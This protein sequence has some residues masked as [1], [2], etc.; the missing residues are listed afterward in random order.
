ML[1]KQSSCE[2]FSSTNSMDETRSTKSKDSTETDKK[3]LPTF[4]N[5]VVVIRPEVFYENEDCQTDNKFMKS[6][7]LKRQSTNDLAQIEFDKFKETLQSGGIK[8]VEFA[9]KDSRAPDAIFPDWFTT[10]KNDDIPEGVFILYPMK[11]HSRQLERDQE[12]IEELSKNYKHFID[13]SGWEEKGKALEGKG[14]L[15]F[16]YRNQKIY[17]SLSP[18]ACGEV[19]AD[20]IVQWNK[21]SQKQ[22]RSVTFTSYDRK[23]NIVYHTDCILT[24]L[25]DHAVICVTAIKDKKERKR[26]LIE[27][28]NPPINN[29][30]YQILEIDR[31]E[32]EGMCANM[33]NLVDSEGRNCIIMSDRARRTYD[34]EKFQELQEN[35]IVLVA[36]IDMIELVGG[37]STRCMLAEKF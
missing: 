4:T 7:G 33:F 18:R 21:I 24:L 27:L 6:S 2:S 26:V 11:H 30:P 31:H 9:K 13:L 36:N 29:K 16:D 32:V 15:V 35:Y 3:Q 10:H 19:V 5:E 14:S 23:G 1:S 12:I 34:P 8:V 28:S 25:N 22:Y 37:G 20:L 17:C